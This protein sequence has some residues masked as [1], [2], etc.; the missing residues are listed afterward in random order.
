MEKMGYLKDRSAGGTC[1]KIIA[2]IKL[3][4]AIFSGLLGHC[5]IGLSNRFHSREFTYWDGKGALINSEQLKVMHLN[6][7][8]FPGSLPC[9]FGKQTPGTERMEQLFQSIEDVQPHLL[10]L[11]EFS[12]VFSPELYDRLKGEYKTFLINIGSNALGNEASLVVVSKIPVLKAQFIPTMVESAGV[13]KFS[14]R[15]YVII[16][17]RDCMYLYAHLHPEE[18]PIAKNIR[19]RQLDEIRHITDQ[20]EKPWV[21]LGD[22]NIDRNHDEYQNMYGFIDHISKET[23]TCEEDGAVE[24][25]DYV[26]TRDKRLQVAT[27]VKQ[28]LKLSDHSIIIATISLAQKQ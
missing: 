10:F 28:D 13:Q 15:G 24:S 16:E 18:T 27:E 4:P 9:H 2:V 25:I 5:L 21:I 11:S 8:M 26:L 17:T 19:R 12:H 23:I 1:E 7:C 22:M 6:V 3:V 20:G 14:Y